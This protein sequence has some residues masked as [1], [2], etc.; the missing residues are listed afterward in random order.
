MV[1]KSLRAS[2]RKSASNLSN[3]IQLFLMNVRRRRSQYYKNVAKKTH[4]SQRRKKNFPQI[5]IK[6]RSKKR[7]LSAKVVIFSIM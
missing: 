3:Y 2:E 4:P 1:N 6:S 7:A 5:I